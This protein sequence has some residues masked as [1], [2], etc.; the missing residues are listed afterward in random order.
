MTSLER[1]II[2]TPLYPL[3][4]LCSMQECPT[5]HTSSAHKEHF[6]LILTSNVTQ[7]WLKNIINQ[8]VFDGTRIISFWQ[9]G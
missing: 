1:S 6:T 9:E 8:P 7:M 5:D 4:C 2:S 3:L